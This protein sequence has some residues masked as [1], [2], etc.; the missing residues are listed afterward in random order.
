MPTS[1]PPRTLELPAL[2][3]EFELPADDTPSLEAY[4]LER[5]LTHTPE[6]LLPAWTPTL[7]AGL[8][9]GAHRSTRDTPGA[10]FFEGFAIERPRKRPERRTAGICHGT[11]PG[12]AVGL[13]AH[14]VHLRESTDSDGHTMWTAWPET[15]VVVDLLDAGRA[16]SE[17]R[18]G[19]AGE[20]KALM[21]LGRSKE[22][23][24]PR[25]TMVAPPVTVE[26]HDGFR[27]R[28][29]PAEDPQTVSAI[30]GGAAPLLPTVAPDVDIEIEHGILCVAVP[31]ALADPAQLDA[32]CR[33][34]S[35]I[36][37]AVRASAAR[38]PLLDPAVSAGPPEP[39]H[40]R[41]WIDDGVATV[42]WKEPPADFPTAVE[43]YRKVNRGRGR[44]IGWTIAFALFLV[45]LAGMAGGLYVADQLGLVYGGI[46]TVVFGLWLAWKLLWGAIRAGGEMSADERDQRAYPWALTAYVRGYASTRGLE[47][48]DQDALRRRFVSPIRGRAT[49]ALHGLLDA[50]VPGH[51]AY[52]TE[53]REDGTSRMWAVAIVAAPKQLGT[54]PAP[55]VAAISGDLLVVAVEVDPARRGP[56]DF[57]GVAGTAVSLTRGAYDRAA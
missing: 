42:E 32:L 44:R 41:R 16:V 4:A 55:Y 23:S 52:W 15:V 47:L 38:F 24:D 14:H 21:T 40:R 9:L 50:G 51:L 25:V 20:V 2:P 3:G 22:S 45:L 26:E 56:A 39:T 28:F 13:V 17:L 30:I 57:D 53:P 46:V 33:L 27:W 5:G 34:A 19:K 37:A 36:V 29:T 35:A 49:T 12:G 48:E 8:G 18:A 54:V 43:A 10:G 1:R 31:G 7:R 6:A 11:L